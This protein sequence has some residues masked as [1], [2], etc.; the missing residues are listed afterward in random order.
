MKYTDPE[1]LKELNA[2]VYEKGLI[3]REH[4]LE[5]LTI[6]DT[7]DSRDIV[8]EVREWLTMLHDDPTYDKVRFPQGDIEAVIGDLDSY[9][10]VQPETIYQFKQASNRSLPLT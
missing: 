3:D 4:I 10:R 6:I 1:K 8:A 9:G 5:L 2:K 7:S